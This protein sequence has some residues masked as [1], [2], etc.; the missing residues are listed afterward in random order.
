VLED[1]IRAAV[2]AARE[3]GSM[4]PDE[5]VARLDALLSVSASPALALRLWRELRAEASGVR[6]LSVFGAAADV[7][8]ARFGFRPVLDVAARPESALVAA[9]TPGCVAVLGLDGQNPWWAR[10]LAEPKLNVFSALPERA[11]NGAFAALAVGMVAV[12]PT[13]M[14]E[15]FWV[16]DAAG[17]SAAIEEALGQV[18]FAGRP[19]AAAAGLKLFAL[20]GFVQREDPRLAD[21]PGRLSGVI[22]AAPVF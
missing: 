11:P 17:S 9:R 20:S 18:G 6:R 8:R 14:D 13:G 3:Q 16:T 7:A 19:V 21:A 15:T 4:T 1:A 5:E 2:Q 10:I 22:G 12:E